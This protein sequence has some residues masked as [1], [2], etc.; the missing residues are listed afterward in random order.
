MRKPDIFKKATEKE[1]EERTNQI[2]SEELAEAKANLPKCEAELKAHMQAA[3]KNPNHDYDCDTCASLNSNIG[4]CKRTIAKAEGTFKR[5]EVKPVPIPK[6][7][8]PEKARPGEVYKEFP[9][10]LD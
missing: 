10:T 1:I 2:I 5:A 6:G 7:K 3:K 8:E 4:D 9:H